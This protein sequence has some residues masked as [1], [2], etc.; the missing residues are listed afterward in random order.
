MVS[1]AESHKEAIHSKCIH[2]VYSAITV[3]GNAQG[4]GTDGETVGKMRKAMREGSPCV[5][6]LLNYK[7]NGV[8]L[9]NPLC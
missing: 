6:Q 7:K 8:R 9:T 3:C 1:I 5:V 2:V 4:E